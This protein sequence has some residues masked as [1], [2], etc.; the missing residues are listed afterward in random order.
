MPTA[1]VDRGLRKEGDASAAR[2]GSF[3]VGAYNIRDG[4]QEGL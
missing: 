4:G 1:V 3:A 2:C